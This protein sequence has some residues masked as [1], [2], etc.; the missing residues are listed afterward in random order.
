MNYSCI[1][2]IKDP[3]APRR[4]AMARGFC[5]LIVDLDSRK[6]D[7][8]VLPEDDKLEPVS[9]EYINVITQGGET[10]VEV[11]VSDFMKKNAIKEGEAEV[12]LVVVDESV[13]ALR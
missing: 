2:L 1:T 6:L 7:L 3:L 12:A 11:R 4:P 10:V 8:Q 9:T 13:L 5:E